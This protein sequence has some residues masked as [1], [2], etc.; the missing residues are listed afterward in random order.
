[1]PKQSNEEESNSLHAEQV[2]NSQDE[3]TENEQP[4]R[5]GKFDPHCPWVDLGGEG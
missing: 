2:N 3:H 5:R 4:R 1:M